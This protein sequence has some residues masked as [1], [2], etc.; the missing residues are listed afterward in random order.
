M[1]CSLESNII[2]A[3]SRDFIPGNEIYFHTTFSNS[4]L[5]PEL[6]TENP[7][8]IYGYGL[9]LFCLYFCLCI[10]FRE[11]RQGKE[12][13]SEFWA[14]TSKK[15]FCISQRIRIECSIY[16]LKWNIYETFQLQKYIFSQNLC[17]IFNIEY[18][19]SVKKLAFSINKS[20]Y[21]YELGHQFCG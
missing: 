8:F 12:L 13:D 10:Y 14:G 4:F 15:K 9:L 17:E 11:R 1:K 3:V 19:G 16:I 5:L 2:S 18:N 6:S 21:D 7:K 20:V